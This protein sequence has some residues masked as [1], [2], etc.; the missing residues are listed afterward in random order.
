MKP[1]F[2]LL[3]L[4]IPVIWLLIGRSPL[5][6]QSKRSRIIIGSI[7]T[8]LILVLGLALSDPRLIQGSDQVNLFFC[9]DVSESIRGML[10]EDGVV[11]HQEGGD[12][13]EGRDIGA[14]SFMRKA[15]AGIG[16][17]DKAGLIIFGEEPSLEI[18][19]KRDFDPL[20][21]KSQ[22][23]KN[24]TNIYEV[25]QLAIGK[26]PQ[27]G[28]NKIIL[29]SD[30]NQNIGDA[31]EMAYLARS[32]GIE[33]YPVP[34][35]SRFNR[36]EV[37]IETLSTPGTIPLETPFD[38]KLLIMSTKEGQGDVILMRNGKLKTV[39]DVKLH[40]GKN[41]LRFVDS[42]I[43]PGLYLYKAV[44]N[45]P[46]D[47]FFQNNEGI[48]FTQGTSKSEVL[49][50]EG[51]KGSA[52]HLIQ[53]LLHQGL[54]VERIKVKDFPPS[55]H[56][57][58]DYSAII[59]DNISGQTLSYTLME[60]IEKY[61]KDMGGGLIMIGGDESFGA[62]RY[63]KTPI[64][65][66]LPV[67]MDVPTDLELPGLSLI[68]VIDKSK[69][70]SGDI[71]SKNKLEG[72]KIAAFSTVE[73]LNPGDK[74]GI[75]AFDVQFQW[76]VPIMQANERREIANRLSTLTSDGGTDLYSALKE[77]SKVLKTIKA[78]KKHVIVLSDG[79]TTE[80][81]FHALIR[82][83]K[84]SRITV[85]TVAVGKDSDRNLLKSISE[86]GGGRSYYT[87]DAAN[88]PRIFVGETKMATK[89]AVFEKT[90][91]PFGAMRGEMVQGLPID[92]L[93]SIRGL[94]VTY[95]KPGSQI[96]ID[97]EE[98]PLLAAWSYGL[99]R[100]VAFTS[101]LSGRWGRNWV[102]WEQFGR[103]ASQMVKWAQRKESPQNYAAHVSQKGGEGTFTI[104]VTDDLNQFVNNLDLKIKVLSPS[105]NDQTISMDQVAPGR[106]TGFFPAKERGEYYLSLFGT[107]E[108]GYSPPQHF[109]FAV[110]YSEEFM[111]KDVNHIL[112]K[113][114]ATITKGRLLDLTDDP[115][116]L[117]RAYSDKKEFGHPLWPYLVL[118]SL[119]LFMVDVAVRKF[120]SL[121]RFL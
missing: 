98:G 94:V 108:E 105:K 32:L 40:S 92:D 43:E 17:E 93:P 62:G 28:K 121:G 3:W 6:I 59:L 69:S 106:Y 36:N 23:N 13:Q 52:E 73:M 79:L 78:A 24:F 2:L 70:M 56:G 54:H 107:E 77:T 39:Q 97:T 111:G 91:K 81:D 112:L 10:R 102:R 101:D 87:D 63:I 12:P 44:I 34:L 19:L 64:E 55:I 5:S 95:P 4:L 30:G 100:S 89:K 104:D 103:F 57:L 109:G 60:N 45:T 86:W 114:L 88:L 11:H 9:L 49:Y 119:L 42:L 99:G 20:P 16:E 84:A 22:V 37:L 80:G 8:M 67:F 66:A 65:K 18:A 50:L 29:F 115:V 51:D 31:V 117:F 7:R 68:L 14:M 74:V 71:V 118:L 72:A 90:I 85:S 116:D 1:I 76:V 35:S 120:Q 113:R 38:I 83:M 82:G 110:P 75:L 61:V 48:S 27:T 33:I 96:M 47:A 53:A 26:L 15:A 21:A 25:L 46:E 58:L 41:V